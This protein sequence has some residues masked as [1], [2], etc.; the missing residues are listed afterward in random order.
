MSIA[1]DH[2]SFAYMPGSPFAVQAL[3]DVSLTAEDGEFIGIIGQT[4][5]GKSTL[6]QQ[7]SGLLKPD[8]GRVLLDGADINASGYGQHSCTTIRL[9]FKPRG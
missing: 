4:G 8:S 2:L 6:I 7:L 1:A 3:D 5:C 9:T